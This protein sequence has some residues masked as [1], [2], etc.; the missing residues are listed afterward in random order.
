MLNL[1]LNGKKTIPDFYRSDL[2]NELDLIWEFQKQFYPDLFTEEFKKELTGKGQKATATIFWARHGFNTAEN[3]GKR[4]EK[5][6]QAYQWRVEALSKQLTKEEVAFVIADINN[7]LYNSSG[8]LGAIS[9]R[10][11]ELYFNQLTVGEYLYQQLESNPHAR[12]KSQVFYRK[13]Y[14]DE[15][16][17]IWETQKQFHAEL[18]D[19]LK[20]EIRDIVIFYQRKLKSQKGL[21]SICEYENKLVDIQVKGKQVQKLVGLRVAPKSSPLFQEFKIWQILHHLEFKN[22][23]TKALFIPDLEEKTKMFEELN[24]KGNLKIERLL[25]TIGCKPKEW[26]SNY[27]EVEGNRTNQVLFDAYLEILQQ[28]GYDEELFKLSGKDDIS[29]NALKTPANELHDMVRRIFDV[30]EINT[31][32]LCFDAQLDGE[33][34]ENQPAYQLWHLLY[35]YEVDESASGNEKLY[36]LLHKKFGFSLEQSKLL[37]KVSFALDYG[38]L[39]TKAMR[40]I[41]PFLAAGHPLSG[42]HKDKA[43]VMTNPCG[44]S[45]FKK[46]IDQR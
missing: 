46:F 32:C 15:F 30:L 42:S 44:L 12:L 9:D 45:P 7:N 14:M 19:E 2:Q 3:K 26:E 11:K 21:I 6:R 34:F 31:Q 41:Y 37:G 8:Y 27:A 20:K 29:V 22:K 13:D 40:K 23:T 36:E 38:S 28:A 10:S 4:D 39:S 16:E 18:T 1:L 43:I 24:L 5:K 35:A 17:I 25:E 33:D